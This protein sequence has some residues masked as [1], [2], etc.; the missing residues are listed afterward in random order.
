ESFG[1]D[2]A[3]C[4]A[5]LARQFHRIDQILSRHLVV[6]AKRKPPHGPIWFPLQ[7]ATAARDRCDNQFFSV[8]ILVGDSASFGIVRRNWYLQNDSGCRRYRQKWRI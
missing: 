7:L 5:D 3:K 1:C 4:P 6:D 2:G 8:R